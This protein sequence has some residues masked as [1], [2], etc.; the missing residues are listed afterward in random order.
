MG[1]GLGQAFEQLLKMTDMVNDPFALEL[2]YGVAGVRLDR[3]KGDSGD[4]IDI[5]FC[6][7]SWGSPPS[8]TGDR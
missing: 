7:L 1:Q 8:V 5:P 4:C 6:F 2:Q 3:K